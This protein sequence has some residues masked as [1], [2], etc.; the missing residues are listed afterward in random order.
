MSAHAQGQGH[1]PLDD[2]LIPKTAF[3]SLFSKYEYLKNPFGLL[4]APAYFEELMKKVL[5]DLPFAI[6][7]IDDIVIYSKTTEEHLKHLQQVF[8]NLWNPKLSMKLSKCHFCK[9]NS[10]F[11]L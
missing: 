9:R 2:G 3:S 4:H 1:I 8:H 6:A 11:G 5:K 7:Y 10:A